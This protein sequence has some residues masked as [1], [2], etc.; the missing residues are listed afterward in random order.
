MNTVETKW[1]T[2][3]EIR[4]RQRNSPLRQSEIP[5]EHAVSLPM[6][7]LRF[8]T[9]MYASFASPAQRQPQQPMRQGA[10]DRWWAVDARS[11]HLLLYA[12]VAVVP[13][14]PDAHWE[15][16]TLPAVASSVEELRQGLA[17]I[18]E[19]MNGLAP[20]FFAGETGEKADRD[21]LT[22]ALLK[23]LPDPI[24]PQYRAVAPDFFAWLEG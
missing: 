7:T 12:G 8:G 9:P 3:S 5:V 22:A 17:Q 18:E 1:L 6:P 23:V 16:V 4:L 13:I 19:K 15:T 11:G 14:A 21:A 2:Y 20:V 10:P 24:V